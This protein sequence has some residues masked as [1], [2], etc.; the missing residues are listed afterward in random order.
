MRAILTLLLLP[1]VF[2]V[3]VVV[4]VLRSIFGPKVVP[5]DGAESEQLLAQSEWFRSLGADYPDELATGQLRPGARINAATGKVVR[6][7]EPT[8]PQATEERARDALR[9]LT[10]RNLKI[11]AVLHHNLELAAYGRYLGHPGGA[12]AA[13][14]AAESFVRQ[15]DAQRQAAQAEGER[16]PWLIVHASFR[17]MGRQF[18][19]G[20][21]RV[22]PELADELKR[23]AMR[24]E[25]HARGRTLA[26]LGHPTWPVFSVENAYL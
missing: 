18:S 16:G 14:G 24:V 23:W 20:R 2:P 8:V 9:A 19:A 3:S 4:W 10:E 22:D 6:P 7:P 12:N 21:E 25:A 11:D 26:S 1:I 15:H 5:L 13:I 17:A